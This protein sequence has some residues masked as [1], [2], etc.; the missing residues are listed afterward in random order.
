MLLES[1]EFIVTYDPARVDE[2]VLTDT[3]KQVGYTAQVVSGLR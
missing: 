2:E 3:V 1:D